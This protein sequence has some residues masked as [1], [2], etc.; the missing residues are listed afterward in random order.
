M[1]N[2]KSTSPKFDSWE[3]HF[4]PLY[5]MKIAFLF[6]VSASCSLTSYQS[7]Y[8]MNSMNAKFT[9]DYTYT[10]SCILYVNLHFFCQSFCSFLFYSFGQDFQILKE[11]TLPSI[12][13]WTQ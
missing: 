7:N 13:L 11:A 12:A 8:S 5:T 2:L 9:Q 10:P 3:S 4:L 1:N 6:L